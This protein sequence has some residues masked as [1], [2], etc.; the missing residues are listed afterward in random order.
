M[1][2]KAHLLLT[3]VILQPAGEWASQG[4]GFCFVRVSEGYG[5][6]LDPGGAKEVASST[7]F[8][9]LPGTA[10]CFR[11]S[12]LS[13]VKLDYFHICP[14]SLTGVLTLPERLYFEDLAKPPK[15]HPFWISQ[16]ETV[17]RLFQEV[18]EASPRDGLLQRVRMLSVASQIFGPKAAKAALA[19]GETASAESRFEEL[20][21]QVPE[22][23]L[24]SQPPIKLAEHCHCTPRHFSRLF[25]KHF[26][27][28]VRAKQ[29]ELRL[30]KA[31]QLLLETDVKISAIAADLG[32]KHIGLFNRMFRKYLGMSP[33][34]W[35]RDAQPKK[36][37]RVRVRDGLPGI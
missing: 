33:S 1:T 30:K 6:W 23:E 3:E 29:T 17:S 22:A 21:Q 4:P 20:M 12:Q 26:G 24:L 11:A 18:V 10:G 31:G 35:R 16:S 25:R 5:Y 28:S 13:S 36:H 19:N 34:Q 32:Y 9:L 2:L 14:E 37:S 27:V 15:R 7:V 8:A